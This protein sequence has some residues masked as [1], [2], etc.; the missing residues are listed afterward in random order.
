MNHPHE[1]LAELID[2]TLDAQARGRVEAHLAACE[3][4]RADVVAATA[5]RSAARSL[6]TEPAPADLYE[7]VVAR[8]GARGDAAGPPGWHRWAGVAAAA[9]VVAAIAIALP[10]V[11]RDADPQG[12]SEDAAA[13]AAPDGEAA[14]VHAGDVAV[15]SVDQDLG[16]TELRDLLRRSAGRGAQAA[17]LDAP[18]V[19]AP[20]VT[21]CVEE[22]L[23]GSPPGRLTR[24]I[25]ARFEGRRARIAVYLEGPGAG[26]PPDTAVAY[27][28]SA[29]ECAMLRVLQVLL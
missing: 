11:G 7:R 28:A 17:S 8:A 27:V 23:Q 19:G 22:A 2:G 6:P 12:A 4:C 15:E 18:T 13:P 20:E 16:E 5:G 10:D 1:L 9:A 21:G 29:D 3:A 14:E 26:Q 25:D 24:L